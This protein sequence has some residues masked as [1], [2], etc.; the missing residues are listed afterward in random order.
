MGEAASEVPQRANAYLSSKQMTMR[1]SIKP[2][3]E[4]QCS[5][6]LSLFLSFFIELLIFSENFELQIQGKFLSIPEGHL[7]FGAEITKKMKLGFL[8]SRIANSILQFGLR[9][10]SLMHY[11]FGNENEKPHITSPLWTA[12]DRYSS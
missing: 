2:V 5:F 11:S 12:V 3:L 1:I 4:D 7:F 9:V 8:T 10:N 6:V